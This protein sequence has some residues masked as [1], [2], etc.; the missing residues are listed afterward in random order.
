MSEKLYECPKCSGDVPVKELDKIARCPDCG[1]ALTINADAEF[2]NGTWR[3]L[4]TIS[5]VPC[6]CHMRSQHHEPMC[7]SVGP[8]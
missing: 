5:I 2:E 1:I 4:T 6:D 8:T 7:P 3:D